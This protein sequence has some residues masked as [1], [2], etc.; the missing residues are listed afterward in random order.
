MVKAFT[1]VEI[2]ITL[3]L[4]SF[5]AV[6]LFPFTIGSVNNANLGAESANLASAIF[7]VQQDAFASENNLNYGIRLNANSYSV[8]SGAD[9]ASLTVSD[10]INLKTPLF[11]SNINLTG[12]TKDIIFAKS[13]LQ[14]NA[15][16]TFIVSNGSESYT[17]NINNEGLVEYQ[18]I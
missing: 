4:M 2:L 18:K 15:S 7:K 3:A 10:T 16:G 12:G 17:F 11:I 6:V 13:N 14:P 5:F 1:L 9:V 8:L